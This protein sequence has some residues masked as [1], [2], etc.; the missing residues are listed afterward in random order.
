MIC[1]Q[2]IKYELF[3][4][5]ISSI[6]LFYFWQGFDCLDIYNLKWMINGDY[7]QSFSSTNMFRYSPF[8]F[9]MAYI[10]N[11]DKPAGGSIIFSDANLF[12]SIITKI[13]S[14]FL[15]N[16]IQ[17]YGFWLF[18]VLLMQLLSSYWVLKQFNI[19]GIYAV[20]GA[21]LISLYPP[22]LFRASA[23]EHINLTAHFLIIFSIGLYFSRIEYKYKIIFLNLLIF[24]SLLIHFYFV[25]IIFGFIVL[26]IIEKYLDERNKI[27]FIKY[28]LFSIMFI[29]LIMFI[30]R[31]F[32]SFVS[33]AAGFGIYSMNLNSLINP[34]GFSYFLGSLSIIDGQYEG[35]QYLGLGSILVLLSIIFTFRYFKIYFSK[36][37]LLFIILFT[38]LSLSNKIYLGDALLLEID[39]PDLFQKLI[40]PVR[41]SGRFFWVV[42]YIVMFIGLVSL[43]RYCIDKKNLKIGIFF[44][45]SVII[46]QIV[47]IQSLLN[48]KSNL[49]IEDKISKYIDVSE[50]IVKN[51]LYT[52]PIYV[53]NSDLKKEIISS[54]VALLGNKIESIGPWIH[55]RESQKFKFQDKYKD[56]LNYVI[57][58]NGIFITNKK[59]TIYSFL[60]LIYNNNNLYVYQVDK[61]HKSESLYTI[62]AREL[63]SQIGII[64]GNSRKADSQRDKSGY[65]T[66]GPYI[67]LLA[68]NYKFN[69]L[70]ESSQNN[71]IEVGFW[72]IAINQEVI[73]QDK[74]YGTNSKE[75]NLI[76]QFT[77]PES[78]NKNI[79][80]IRNYYNGTGDLTIKNLTITRV[81]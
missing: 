74:I 31:Y 22:F 5:I 49:F 2:R 46:I 41:A 32:D 35:F 44:L 38:I 33:T 36:T 70:Y 50:Y 47:D 60:K 62:N 53:E 19:I 57:D 73:N 9:P 52:K 12:I 21:I 25:P 26:I 76:L 4:L 67:E 51:E 80:E 24:L 64:D 17:L 69:I 11:V 55:I 59:T 3:L 81:Y 78:S 15:P 23:L 16:N 10:S 56:Y 65:L 1:N 61:N 68:G 79:V 75:I 8:D 72:D 27:L 13:L 6:V 34:I 28:F 43:Y 29:L 48:K 39:L 37:L 66:F 18:L 30:F 20:F 71:N 54:L 45:I 7:V 42:G 63:P 58:K 40:S 14:P 77:I